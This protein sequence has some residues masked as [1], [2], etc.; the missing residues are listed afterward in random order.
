MNCYQTSARQYAQFPLRIDPPAP[1][2]VI[3]TM[4][5][6]KTGV[7]TGHT[8]LMHALG[9]VHYHHQGIIE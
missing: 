5:A 8:T 6:S 3:H 7:D 9:C 4:Q 1:Q 2:Q